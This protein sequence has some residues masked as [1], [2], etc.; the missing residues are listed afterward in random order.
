MQVKWLLHSVTGLR[1]F[2]RELDLSQWLTF[3]GLYVYRSWA[4]KIFTLPGARVILPALGLIWVTLLYWALPSLSGNQK[5]IP[6][7]VA[8]NTLLKAFFR[9][10]ER[11]ISFKQNTLAFMSPK[12][13]PSFIVGQPLIL[14]S[15]NF[16]PETPCH[17]TPHKQRLMKNQKKRILCLDN[18]TFQN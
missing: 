4:S 14:H 13:E 9:A 5:P 6:L 10:S 8:I 16:L 11:K 15:W 3:E 7:W 17:D 1:C 12:R 18:K 2:R